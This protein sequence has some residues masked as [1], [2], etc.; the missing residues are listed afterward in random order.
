L[1]TDNP[2]KEV[3]KP[4][5]ACEGSGQICSFKGVS[6]FALTW[7]D[8]PVCDGMGFTLPEYDRERQ[9]ESPN[10]GKEKK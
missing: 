6:R 2:R 9:D 5:E 1:K 10:N 7:E 3:K 4:C 8:C